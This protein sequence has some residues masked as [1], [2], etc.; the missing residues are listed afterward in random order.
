V[1]GG[2]PLRSP[3]ADLLRLADAPAL[4]LLELRAVR[5]F[6]LGAGVDLGFAVDRIFFLFTWSSAL[7]PVPPPS[8]PR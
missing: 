4:T 2:L 5:F 7:H 8:S 6:F 1:T 3:A